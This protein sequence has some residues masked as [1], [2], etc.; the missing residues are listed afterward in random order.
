MN[1]RGTIE[2]SICALMI[3]GVLGLEACVDPAHAQDADDVWTHVATANVRAA[4]GS[5]HQLRGKPVAGWVDDGK[6]GKVWHEGFAAETEAECKATVAEWLTFGYPLVGY[7]LYGPDT[8]RAWC[9]DTRPLW[10]R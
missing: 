9:R 2:A 7:E 6:G 3:V 8:G 4:D 1:A 10:K 5:L